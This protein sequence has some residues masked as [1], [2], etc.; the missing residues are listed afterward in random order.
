MSHV[1]GR[2]VSPTGCPDRAELEAFIVGCLP[3]AA[4]ARVADHVERCRECEGA[5]ERLDNLADPLVA[6]LRHLSRA[7]GP[8]TQEVPEEWIAAARSGAAPSSAAAWVAAEEGGRRLGKFELLE[9]LGAGSF[10]YVFRARDD[11]LGRMVA[12]KVPRAGCLASPED[13]ARFLREAR[14]AARLHHPGIVALHETGQTEDGTP[15]LVEEYVKGT[16]LTNLPG[17]RPLSP[18]EAADLIAVVA[19]ALEYAHRHGVVHRDIKPS[20]ILLDADGRPHV[21]DF[22]LAKQDTEEPPVTQE[23]Q[24]LGTPAYMSP[25]QA[26]GESHQ[27]DARS[28]IYSLGVVL[29]ELL[30]GERPFRG[31]RRML[32]LQV[33]EDEPRP[34]RKLNDRVPRDLETICLKAMAKTPSRR[35]ASARELA[36]DLRRYLDGEPIRARPIGRAERLWHW[37]RRNPLAASFLLAVSLGSAFGLWQLSLLSEYLVRSTALEGAAQQSEMLDAFMAHYSSEVVERVQSHGVDVTHDYATKDGAIPLPYT[38]AI[39]AGKKVGVFRLY[40]DYPFRSRK[41]GGPQDD[42]E[43]AALTD[44]RREPA[45]PVY[46]FDTF[47]GSPTLRY[48]TARRMQS[49]CVHC[50]NTHP[51]STKRDWK[52]G[53]VRGV[54]EIIRPLDRDIA[55]ARRGLRGAFVLMAVVSATLLVLSGLAILVTS[56]REPGRARRPAAGEASP[57]DPVKESDRPFRDA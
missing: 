52:E 11:E 49:S 54:L 14:S 45:S 26:R 44:L 19:E 28:D 2:W 32:I 33:L 47:R 39:E 41:D 40:S 22:G 53:E 36:D 5:L 17:N 42:F 16:T 4:F 46:R 51:A 57:G 10:G 7:E 23:G 25:E 31:S 15:Y 24:V 48:A 18:R 20:N 55:R 1:K 34:P 38:F 8:R 29:Y 21:M 12:I 43:R 30:T 35:Y 13:A 6:G 50:H 9:R 27:V 37:T 56:R 3:A